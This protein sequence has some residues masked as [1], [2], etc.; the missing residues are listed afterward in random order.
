MRLLLEGVAPG[1]AAKQ[2][3]WAKPVQ[4]S[5]PRTVRIFLASSNELL[6]DRDAFENHFRRENDRYL[7]T[8]QYL[9]IERWENF[10]DTV[11]STRKQDD[12]NQAIKDC[13]IFVSLFATKAGKFTEEEFDTAYA[14]F[15]TDGTPVIFTFF[16]NVA[17]SIGDV[18]RE[19]M[20]SLWEMQDKLK[21]LGHFYTTYENLQDLNLQ[22]TSQLQKLA[23]KGALK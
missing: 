14:Q 3:D 8:G 23:D 6:A 20:K 11:S 2:P 19:D 16:K 10:L 15:K 5:I 21:K 4:P 18:V 1:E 22:F 7:E 17:V 9:K 12:Y 13:D